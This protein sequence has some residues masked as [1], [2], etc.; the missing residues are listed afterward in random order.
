LAAGGSLPARLLVALQA[1]LRDY[2]RGDE[3]EAFRAA[4]R[5]WP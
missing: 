4:R 3:A 5:S 2:E 1:G